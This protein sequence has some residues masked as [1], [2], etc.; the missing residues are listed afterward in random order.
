MSRSYLMTIDCGTNSVRSI[1][2]DAVTG[3]Q[4]SVAQRDW[5]HKESSIPGAIDFDTG[6]NWEL[7]R[8]CIS[9]SLRNQSID[10]SEIA[11]VTAT[12][13][14]HG[15]VCLDRHG[16]EIFGCIN[17]DARAEKQVIKLVKDGIASEIYGIN[18]DWPS[19]QALPRLMWMKENQP[20]VYH[21]IWRMLMASDWVVYKLCEATVSEP[22]NASSTALFDLKSRNWSDSIVK[23]CDLR[24]DIFPEIVDAGTVVGEVSHSAA[25]Q[26]GL[27][28][29]T[30]VVVGPADTQ[31][32]LVGIGAIKRGM[33][34]VVGGTFWLETQ[35]LDEPKL[36]ME[37]RLRTQC[38]CEPNQWI[39]EGCS[40]YIGLSIRWF[41]NAFCQYEYETEKLTGIDSYNLLDHMAQSVPIGSY[42]VQVILSDLSNMKAWKHAAPSFVGWDILDAEKS[43]K[44]VFF[45]A[46]LENAALQTRGEFS[47]IKSITGTGPEVITFCGGCSKSFLWPQLLADATG[48]KVRVPVVKEGTALGAAIY[49]GKGVGLYHDTQDA[50]DKLVKFERE[51]EPNWDNHAIYAKLYSQWRVLYAQHLAMM[52]NGLTKPMWR[53]AGA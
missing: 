41:R 30:P 45:H 14:R 53:A 51:L 15:I 27:L 8:I 19:I 4:V 49:A 25:E 22:S 11:A 43:H 42:G 26:T 31:A 46:M 47:T 9:D 36:D 52:E 48:A 35:V 40:F 44:G 2:F 20:E 13:F 23:M 17:V 24:G 39:I 38:H 28:A 1:I 5:Y 10:P 12:S 50:I 33:S 6:A 18:G 3:I 32:G 37:M 7:L 34:S 21:N 16:K 29:G